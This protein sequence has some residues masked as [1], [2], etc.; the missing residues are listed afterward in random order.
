MNIVEPINQYRV[1]EKDKLIVQFFDKKRQITNDFLETIDVL[2][3]NK[4]PIY[5]LYVE[6]FNKD[7][8]FSVVCK[9]VEKNDVIIFANGIRNRFKYTEIYERAYKIYKKRK[10]DQDININKDDEINLLRQ[11]LA[12]LQKSIKKDEKN[13][14]ANKKEITITENNLE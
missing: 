7:D 13:K 11:E 4:K 5:D 9:N 2:D 3:E 8:P 10:E 14:N 12:K 1:E 6:I